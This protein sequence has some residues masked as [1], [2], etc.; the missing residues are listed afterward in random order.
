MTELGIGGFSGGLRAHGGYLVVET[1]AASGVEL[2]IG[3]PWGHSTPI[4]DALSR[5]REIRHL[6]GRHGQEMDA[7]QFD[8]QRR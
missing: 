6:L 3:I 1:L 5:H 4:H 2:V 7:R 8:Y